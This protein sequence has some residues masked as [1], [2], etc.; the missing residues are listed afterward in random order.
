M[1]PRQL[2][3]VPTAASTAVLVYLVGYAISPGAAEDIAICIACLTSAHLGGTIS[4]SKAGSCLV[5][6]GRCSCCHWAA[7]FSS[8]CE[9]ISSFPDFF[10]SSSSWAYLKRY[11]KK[12]V[13]AFS[14]LLLFFW[15]CPFLHAFQRSCLYFTS[16]RISFYLLLL[17]KW[18]SWRD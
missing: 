9:V 2:A 6:Q 11:R 15:S 7:T 12:L 18:C 3:L 13:C 16:L 4:N 1:F 8:S 17:H 14:L 10:S 5:N